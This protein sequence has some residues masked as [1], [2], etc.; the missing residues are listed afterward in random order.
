MNDRALEK[1]ILVI[2]GMHCGSCQR[3]ITSLLSDTEG[4]LEHNVDFKEGTALITYSPQVI[5]I[6][7]IV[8]IINNTGSY[9]VISATLD[10]D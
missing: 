5:K 1:A 9:K 6:D 3:Y 2:E 10:E 8:E 7:E 4:V